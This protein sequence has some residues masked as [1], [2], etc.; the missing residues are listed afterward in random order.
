MF[1]ICIIGGG[2]AG[3][4]A[5]ITAK[6]SN[7]AL[8]VL[9]IERLDRFG[10]K[11]SLTGNGRC[12]ITNRTIETKNY[13]GKNPRFTEGFFERFCVLDTIAFF[14]KIGVPIIFE[15]D[16][17]YPRS[18]QAASV[19]DALRFRVDELHI[20]TLFENEVRSIYRKDDF[21]DI[22]TNDKHIRTKTLIAAGGLCS[23]GAKIGCDGGLLEVLKKLGLKA[24]SPSP[25]IVQLKTDTDF[26]RQLKGIKVNGKATIMRN[27]KVTRTEQGEILFCDYGISGPPILQLSGHC[28][29]GDKISI[30]LIP[31]I[32]YENLLN[33]LKTR[34]KALISRKCDE[35]LSG[36]LNKRLGQVVIK[37]AG[38]KLD[39]DVKSIVGSLDKICR[40]CKDF[41]LEYKGNTGF[42]NSQV[43]KGGL[44]TEQ[45]DENLMCKSIKGLFAAGEILDIDGDCGGFNLQWAW[46]S[47]FCAAKGAVEYLK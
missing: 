4:V 13:H 44:L 29:N 3:L 8:K 1:D 9:L 6:E 23:G 22:V 15:G 42:L 18:L 16:K 28:Q 21:F 24:V 5:A 47:G 43:S 40:V 33:M 25:A 32:D 38:L 35:F 27:G 14:E 11:I 10:K 31:D 30:D 2:A 17:A 46:S 34:Q 36:L 41:S 37:R 26:V 20:E 7:P 45:F 39:C 12:N 19:T